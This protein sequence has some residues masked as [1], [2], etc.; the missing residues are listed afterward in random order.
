VTDN[1][2]RMRLYD[3]A[4]G[5]LRLERMPVGEVVFSPDGLLMAASNLVG[6]VDLF[7]L[8]E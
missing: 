3:P 7:E 2:G 4:S 1:F 6:T 8:K 5:Q